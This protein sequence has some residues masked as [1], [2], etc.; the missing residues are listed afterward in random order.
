[1]SRRARQFAGRLF[2]LAESCT[3]RVSR[4]GR[5]HQ[6]ETAVLINVIRVVLYT[7]RSRRG[8]NHRRTHLLKA[9]SIARSI[10]GCAGFFAATSRAIPTIAVLGD[11]AFQSHDARLPEHDCAVYVLDMLA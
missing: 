6:N 3:V 7:G 8:D 2:I 10:A 11:D 9:I 5:W 4:T 1:M